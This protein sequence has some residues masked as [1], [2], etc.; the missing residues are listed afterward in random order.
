MPGFNVQALESLP[1][2]FALTVCYSPWP[3]LASAG[4]LPEWVHPGPWVLTH[5]RQAMGVG[6]PQPIS[7]APLQGA[8]AALAATA[9]HGEDTS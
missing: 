5:P 8:N 9:A 7:T 3:T 1:H 2:T 6:A 4:L